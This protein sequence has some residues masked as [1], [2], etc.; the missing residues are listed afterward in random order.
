LFGLL[1]FLATV[2]D[3]FRLRRALL[4][5]RAAARGLEIPGASP[6]SRR[7]EP[8]PSITVIRPVRGLDVDAANNVAAALDNAYPGQVDTI[9]VFDDELDPAFAV[10]RKAIATHVAAGRSGT[11]TIMVA[12]PPPPTMTG[13]LHAMIAGLRRAR[14][15]LVAFGDSD[16]RPH[17]HSLHRAVEKLLTT[18]RAGAAF[19]PVVATEPPLTAGDAGAALMLNGL[20]GP[21][22]AGTVRKTGDMPF[23]MGQL[24][25]FRR[26]T[27]K[28]LRD[29]QS[30]RGEL[31]DD[32]RIG[33]QA[34]A[35]GYRNVVSD[36][37][38]P[39]V[40]RGLGLAEFARMFRRWLIFSRSGLP[41]WSFKLPVWLRGL[42]FWLGFLI[43]TFA[44]ADRQYA[45]AIVAAATVVAVSVSIVRLH[46]TLGG[47]A[48]GWRH[49]WVPAALLLLGPL[50]LV[51]AIIKPEVAWRGRTYQ[52]DARSKLHRREPAHAHRP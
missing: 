34:V 12:G 33:I 23:I 46:R 29:L 25:V 13:K 19:V 1:L 16:T 36:D 45:A 43:A 26:E 52:L 42:E 28:A 7:A 49:A 21:A 50:V 47:A 40:I 32:M 14:G 10:V 30:V 35:A 22:V 20:Y 31:V 39:V 18:P 27:L 51:S 37:T 2:W 15:E 9:F 24:M 17:P 38:L 5:Q 44:L 48:I 6:G 3:H 41:S 8:L 11:A 4:D